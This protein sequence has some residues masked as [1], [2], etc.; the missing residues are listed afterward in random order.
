MNNTLENNNMITNRLIPNIDWKP[1]VFAKSYTFIH[2]VILFI[3]SI[4]CKVK[5][6]Y[7]QTHF[8]SQYDNSQFSSLHS[9]ASGCSLSVVEMSTQK[10]P[11]S[12]LRAVLILS[13]SIFNFQLSTFNSRKLPL[14]TLHS[15]LKN[16]STKLK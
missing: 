8:H 6:L 11:L 7:T 15:Q 13:L 9:A 4:M 16:L 12:V 2:Y 10:T 3:V 5:K 1:S 14:S